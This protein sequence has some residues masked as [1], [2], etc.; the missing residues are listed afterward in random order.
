MPLH[1]E[2]CGAV[3]AVHCPCAWI[4]MCNGINAVFDCII[5]GS[6]MIGL[7]SNFEQL[8]DVQRPVSF[9]MVCST[10]CEIM[11]QSS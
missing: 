8:A 7:A 3:C 4:G 2:I 6:S 5:W 9:A 1:F 10:L 11:C